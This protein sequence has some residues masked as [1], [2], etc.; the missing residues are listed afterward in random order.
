MSAARSVFVERDRTVTDEAFADAVALAWLMPGPVAV[1]VAIRLGA[2]MRGA[3]GALVMGMATILPFFIVMSLM[4]VSYGVLAS[5]RQAMSALV[6]G[7]TPAVCAA[8]LS[9]ARN[10]ARS[11]LKSR[12]DILLAAVALSGLLV[13]RGAFAPLAV[14][15]GAAFSGYLLY[16][17][18]VSEGAPVTVSVLSGSGILW[19]SLLLAVS[20]TCHVFPEILPAGQGPLTVLGTFSGVSLTLFGG[21]LVAVPILHELLVDKMHWLDGMTF[22]AGIASSQVSPGPLLSSAAF[23]GYRINGWSGAFFATLGMF[24]PPGVLMLAMASMVARLNRFPW[25]ARCIR[26]TRVAVIGLTCASV[27]SVASGAI[28]HWA[29]FIIFA[30]A[31]ILMARYMLQAALV[32]PLGGVA[33][34]LIFGGLK[35]MI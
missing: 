29:S 27:V 20:V 10:Q 7:L 24:G 18:D 13:L 6:G 14:M 9:S 8:I 4:A 35:S 1:N 26:G 34:F 5:H 31:F 28:A 23:M 17:G 15:L 16:P 21:G 30:G 19:A 2:L 11:L 12:R 25:F 33:G 22:F 32:V 3:R